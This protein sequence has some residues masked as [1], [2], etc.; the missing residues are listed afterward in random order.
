MSWACPSLSGFFVHTSKTTDNL[1]FTNQAL[2]NFKLLTCMY[3]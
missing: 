3:F 1:Q 2:L